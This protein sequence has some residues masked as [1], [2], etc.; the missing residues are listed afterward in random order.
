MS[1]LADND[2]HRRRYGGKFDSPLATL[3]IGISFKA[4]HI[5]INQRWT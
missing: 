5:L 2:E 1:T 3:V 4:H